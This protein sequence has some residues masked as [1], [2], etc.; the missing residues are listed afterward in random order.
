MPLTSSSRRPA[1]RTTSI[2]SDYMPLI[3]LR[4]DGRLR[5]PSSSKRS[6]PLLARE[7]I[8]AS[9]HAT[10]V[11]FRPLREGRYDEVRRKIDACTRLLDLP[12][13]DIVLCGLES[14]SPLAP[15]LFWDIAH[16]RAVGSTITLMQELKRHSYLELP[17]F[18]QAFDVVAKDAS[19][20]VL[21]KTHALPAETELGLDRWSFGI[22]VGPD[23]ATLLNV[24]VK[25]ILELPIPHKEIV[26]CGRP[27]AN[28]QYWDEVRIVGEDITAP[29]VQIC[30]KKNRIALEARYENLCIIHDRVFLPADF[31]NAMQRFGDLYPFVALQSVY[32]DDRFNMVPRRYSDYGTAPRV[33]S[34]SALG[35]MRDN[36]ASSPSPFSPSVFALT[37][38]AGFY[39]ANPARYSRANYNTG[40]LYICKRSVWLACPQNETLYWTEFEDLEQAYR[41]ND[42]GIPSRVNPY[43]LTQSLI[44]RPLLSLAGAIFYEAADGMTRAYRPSLE[45]LPIPRKPLI[46]V[47]RDVAAVSLSRFIE[48]YSPPHLHQNVSAN[49]VMSGKARTRALVGAVQGVR[50]PIRR[51][52]VRQLLKDFEKQLSHDQAPYNWCEWAETEFVARGGAALTNLVRDNHQ[53]INHLS[54]RQRGQVFAD[55]L[56]DFLPRPGPLLWFGTLLSAIFLSLKNR[57]VFYLRGTVF[58]RFKQLMSTTPFAR[59][60]SPRV[61]RTDRKT[62][63]VNQQHDVAPSVF[64]ADTARTEHI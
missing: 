58:T 28:F 30:A 15:L 11:S 63:V 22:P 20:T 26:L 19:T 31:L 44:A 42:L 18:Q 57:Q 47:T 21:R 45:P 29:P 12:A 2:W 7:A 60:A 34:Q 17:Y 40:S 27:G 16:T 50:I 10:V 6:L 14:D 3:Q 56:H 13:G 24:V 59:Y 36:D 25:R 62:G 32:F 52:A 54:Q 43:A 46:K 61:V 55:T 5:Y 35:L 51:N 23:D 33:R 9:G 64:R 49:A 39:Y 38:K 1:Q 53:M 41:A 8:E 48:K 37:E 4:H